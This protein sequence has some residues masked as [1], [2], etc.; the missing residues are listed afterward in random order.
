M[1]FDKSCT[2][3]VQ[4]VAKLRASNRDPQSKH[5]A[6]SRSLGQPMRLAFHGRLA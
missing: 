6:K 5:G 2:G 1:A 3:L 4:I